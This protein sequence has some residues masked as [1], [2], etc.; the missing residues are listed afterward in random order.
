[1]S[2]D[3]RR[4]DEATRC[5][6]LLVHVCANLGEITLTSG[7]LHPL[8]PPVGYLARELGRHPLQSKV[9]PGLVFLCLSLAA[10]TW[11]KWKW[12]V[13]QLAHGWGAGTEGDPVGKTSRCVLFLPLDKEFFGLRSNRCF[14]C[15]ETGRKSL[16]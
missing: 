11:G 9:A 7:A 13:G 14:V 1:M 16:A 2:P 12:S 6:G 3:R 10:W 8:L 15:R 5:L 4:R